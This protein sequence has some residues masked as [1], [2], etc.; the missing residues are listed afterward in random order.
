MHRRR[1]VATYSQA[2]ALPQANAAS[3]SSLPSS[4][5]IP[6]C[7]GPSAHLLSPAG[8]PN[9]KRALTDGQHGQTDV[10]SDETLPIDQSLSFGKLHDLADGVSDQRPDRDPESDLVEPCDIEPLSDGVTVVIVDDQIKREVWRVDAVMYLCESSR[11]SFHS[12]GIPF[13]QAR[14]HTYRGKEKRLHRS[15]RTRPAT[16]VGYARAHAC[17]QTFHRPPPGPRWDPSG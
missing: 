7:S 12:L 15:I 1:G 8:S 6:K 16:C 14:P 3:R 4:V 2:K 9:P 10:L 13:H 11:I 17:R 5:Q